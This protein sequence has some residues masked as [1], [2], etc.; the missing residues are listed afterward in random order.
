LWFQE[1][2]DPADVTFDKDVFLLT[3]Q[4]AEALRQAEQQPAPGNGKDDVEDDATTPKP[5]P[6]PNPEPAPEPSPDPAP[7]KLR[8]CVAGKIPPEVWNRVGTKI[9][10]KLRDREDFAITISLAADVASDVAPGLQTELAQALQ[11]LGIA[12][13]VTV[14]GN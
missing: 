6:Q 12:D 14:E 5:D 3:K 1:P 10:P 8:L 13:S 11:D 4:Q 9:L 2:V 7:A